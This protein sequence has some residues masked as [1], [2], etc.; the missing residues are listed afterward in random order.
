MAGG[1][2]SAQN[3]PP[4]TRTATGPL[5]TGNGGKGITI[6]VPAPSLQGGGRADAWMPQLLQDLITGD[7]ARYSAMTVL[8]RLNE[9]LVLAEQ[10]LSA[11][12]N[13]S[14]DDYIAMGRLANAKYIAAGTIQR[15]S[16]R[17]SV[18]F[19]INDTETNAIRASFFKRSR[20][21]KKSFPPRGAETYQ[22]GTA[23]YH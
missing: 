23:C 3:R 10:E 5:F 14:D 18:S 4:S 12:G 13:Y 11:S 9:S 16:G 20:L 7:L 21:R 1:G 8:D 17:Y 2:S 6:A 22:T 15:L 19:R